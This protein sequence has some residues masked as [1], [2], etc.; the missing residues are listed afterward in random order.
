MWTGTRPLSSHVLVPHCPPA[1][2]LPAAAS[3]PHTAVYTRILNP[4]LN[5]GIKR[6]DPMF[7][8]AVTLLELEQYPGVYT[9]ALT[10]AF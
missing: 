10:A 6:R 4:V 2:G 1:A 5:P 9:T 7:M 3:N 8:T